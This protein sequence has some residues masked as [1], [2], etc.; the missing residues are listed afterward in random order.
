MLTSCSVTDLLEVT[1]RTPWIQRQRS[2]LLC[3]AWEL[4]QK[5]AQI[6]RRL[7]EVYVKIRRKWP[8]CQLTWRHYNRKFCCFFREYPQNDWLIL[9]NQGNDIILTHSIALHYPGQDQEISVRFWHG[10]WMKQ[11]GRGREILAS[12]EDIMLVLADVD[13]ILI[14]WVFY[15]RNVLSWS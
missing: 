6:L 1:S 11:A 3:N 2:S 4:P 10:N 14:R 5:S 13:N 15:C 8:T 12:R 7:S 9:V